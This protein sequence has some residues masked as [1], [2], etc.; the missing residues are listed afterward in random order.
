MTFRLVVLPRAKRQLSDA[1]LWWA[2]HRSLAEAARWLEKIEAA[3]QNL[4][5]DAERY[6]LARESAAFDF[7]LRQMNFGVSRRPTHRVLFSIEND[8]VIVYAVRHLAQ[9]DLTPDDLV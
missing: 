8:S 1:A 4:A 6:S 5:S 7:E 3:I 9:Q 2:D